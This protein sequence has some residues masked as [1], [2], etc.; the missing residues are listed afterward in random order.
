MRAADDYNG[1]AWNDDIMYRLRTGD[2]A[3]YGRVRLI[4]V[5][6][7]AASQGPC[8]VVQCM[9]LAEP[10]PGAPLAAAGY[11]RLRWSFDSASEPWPRLALVPLSGVQRIVHI[12]P[13]VQLLAPRGLIEP[14]TVHAGSQAHVMRSQFFLNNILFKSTTPA[15]QRAQRLRLSKMWAWF[16]LPSSWALPRPLSTLGELIT[17]R[18]TSRR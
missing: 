2:G 8:A 16:L 9:K 14:P 17:P 1:A 6:G 5:A 15:L 18:L 3:S 10:I 11:Q 13:D 7:L 4:V 12:V